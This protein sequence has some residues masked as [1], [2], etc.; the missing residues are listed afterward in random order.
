MRAYELLPLSITNLFALVVAWAELVT[1]VM[2]VVGLRLRQSAGAIFLLLFMFTVAIITTLVRGL[3][4]DCG[5]FSN[6]GG[7]T[8]NYTLV[9]RNLFLMAGAAIVMRF[10]T[11][12]L[13]VDSLLP[14]RGNN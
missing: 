1:G 7:S 11:D 10:G 8:T 3:A 12:Y 13:T 9:I 5:C 6:E 2:L 14:R 4:I